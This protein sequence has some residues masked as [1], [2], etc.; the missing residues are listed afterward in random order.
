VLTGRLRRRTPTASIGAITAAPAKVTTTSE[1][2]Y[3]VQSGKSYLVVC[4][5]KSSLET[6]PR[7]REAGNSIG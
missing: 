2:R 7:C 1:F 4:V 3:V 6:A 5:E